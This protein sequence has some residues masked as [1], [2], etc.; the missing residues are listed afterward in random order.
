MFLWTVRYGKLIIRLSDWEMGNWE[1]GEDGKL[2]KWEIG[3][4]MK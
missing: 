4:M 1:I 3:K 2:G